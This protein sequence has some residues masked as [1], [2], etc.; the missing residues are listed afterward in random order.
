[1]DKCDKRSSSQARTLEQ[2]ITQNGNA[3]VRHLIVSFIA[4]PLSFIDFL[5]TDIGIFLPPYDNV[6]IYCR[7][8]DFKAAVLSNHFQ[9]I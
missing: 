8:P 1:M 2:N 6:T 9:S 4:D 5:A 3:I 7:S